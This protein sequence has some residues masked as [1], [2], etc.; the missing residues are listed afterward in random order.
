MVLGAATGSTTERKQNPRCQNQRNRGP[1][2]HVQFCDLIQGPQ[3]GRAGPN[4]TGNS[5]HRDEAGYS[6]TGRRDGNPPFADW[7]PDGVHREVSLQCDSA[8]PKGTSLEADDLTI[9]AVDLGQDGVVLEAKNRPRSSSSA[10]PSAKPN[11]TQQRFS[12]ASRA[13]R[14]LVDCARRSGCRMWLMCQT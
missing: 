7:V 12:Q 9:D 10:L 6:S 8:R 11:P 14:F 5:L 1:A 3:D 2:S 4:V 13:W